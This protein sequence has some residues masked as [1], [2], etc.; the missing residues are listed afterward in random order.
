MAARELLSLHR[1]ELTIVEVVGERR[2][3]R[4]A[5]WG[6]RE[7][8]GVCLSLSVQEVLHALV[9]VKAAIVLRR[10]LEM[11]VQELIVSYASIPAKGRVV[12]RH[13]AGQV[14]RVDVVMH[15]LTVDIMPIVELCE[16][17]GGVEEVVRLRLYIRRSGASHLG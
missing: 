9:E 12:L 17:I 1:P 3:N 7:H 4:R 11:Q 15:M 5:V 6:M 8:A 2:L 13:A 14:G 10:A 16:V